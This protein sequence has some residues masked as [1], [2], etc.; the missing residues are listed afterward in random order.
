MQQQKGKG[1][2]S[3]VIYTAAI[4]LAYV[5]TIFS[6]VLFVAVAI[7]WIIPDKKIEKMIDE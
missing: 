6:G 3:L 2:A 4:P 5:N 1:I 7:M